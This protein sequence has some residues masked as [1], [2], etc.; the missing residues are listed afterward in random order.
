[1]NND[2]TSNTDSAAQVAAEATATPDSLQRRR[3][4]LSGLGKGSAALAALSP[5]ASQAAGTHKVANATLTGG[6]GYCSVSGFQSAAISGG[7]TAAVCSAYAPSHF[8]TSEALNYDTLTGLSRA[9]ATATAYA[10]A[11]ADALNI[12][13]GLTGA[14][15]TSSAKLKLSLLASTPFKLQIPG[16]NLTFLPGAV[17]T[18]GIALRP[19]NL[20][21]GFTNAQVAFNSIFTSSGT[22]T[23]LLEVLYEGVLSSTPSTAR[24]YFAAAY[25]TV[26]ASRPAS[27]PVGFDKA[28]VVAQYSDANAASGTNVYKFFSA[29]SVS[30]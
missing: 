17:T 8:V 21:A 30:S 20:P 27:L 2:Q 5:L 26:F 1:M 9:S 7:T 18:A 14:N 4:L 15:A 10:R 25:L 24:C 12:K 16:A 6:F 11:L 29:I 23:P 13:F 3:A 28:Y 22:G 19:Q